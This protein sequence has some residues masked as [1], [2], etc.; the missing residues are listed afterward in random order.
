MHTYVFEFEK[1]ENGK[2]ME[3][4]HKKN[5][6][7]ENGKKHTTPEVYEDIHDHTRRHHGQHTEMMI[8]RRQY[9]L[10]R[11]CAEAREQT[12]KRDFK[13]SPTSGDDAR[14]GGVWDNLKLRERPRQR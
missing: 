4:K 8:I 9:H 14:E 2:K 1:R 10:R 5:G 13:P 7:R 11:L 6:R 3:E 12:S